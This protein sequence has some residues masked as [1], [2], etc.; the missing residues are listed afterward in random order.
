MQ[1]S[2]KIGI[3]GGTFDPIH[4]GHLITAE[5]VKEKFN[6][7]KILF[8]PAGTPPHKSINQVTEAEH[9]YNMVHSAVN[10]NP[11]F[12]VSRIEVDRKGYTYTV[13]TLSQLQ[14]S[15]G[16]GTEFYFII[17]ADVVSDLLNWKAPERVFSLCNFIA[18]FRP[19][20]ERKQFSEQISFLKKSYSAR[21]HTIDVPLI[22]ISSTEVRNRVKN[23]LSIRYLVPHE[24]EQYIINNKLYHGDL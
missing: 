6:L 3:S 8:I 20:Y 2:K 15:Y 21:I 4:Y 7:D 19:G 9:R 16:A 12:E 24:V 1:K 18:V 11:A 10:D 22:E 14:E 23:S 17:G 5:R 13:D